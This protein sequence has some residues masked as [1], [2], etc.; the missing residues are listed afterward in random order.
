MLGRLQKETRRCVTRH[1]Q[2]T[3]PSQSLAR[4]PGPLINGFVLLLRAP[5]G[6]C[7]IDGLLLICRRMWCL[8]RRRKLGPRP[9]RGAVLVEDERYGHQ[10]QPHAS[11]ERASPAYTERVEHVLRKE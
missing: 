8:V 5:A 4:D 6:Q 2:F 11:N 7:A 1:G 9:D 3:R 10:Q